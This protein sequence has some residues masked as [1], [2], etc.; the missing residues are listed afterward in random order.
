MDSKSIDFAA[1]PQTAIKF[2]TSPALFYREMPKNGGFVEPLVF[3]LVMGVVS[4]LIMAV[5][6]LLGLN[7][8]GGMAAGVTSIIFF[9]IVVVIAGF[10]GAAIYFVIWK[11]MGSQENYETAYRCGAYASAFS[12]IL[13]IV[14]LIPY[15]GIVVSMLVCLY[16]L[17]V[18]S[19]EVHKIPS[20]KAWL[21]FGIFVAILIVV[22]VS[23]QMAA[24]KF[25]GQMKETTKQ[26][27]DE[28]G[29]AAKSQQQAVPP[30]GEAVPQASQAQE[31]AYKQMDEAIRQM[32][33]QMSSLPPDQQAQ[34]RITIDQMK[35]A[36]NKTGR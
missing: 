14:G 27:Q 31:A 13:T 20:G 23:G 2:I 21:V 8:A 32:E 11:L 26:M 22:G 6:S 29:E 16:L 35:A 3:M 9:P 12:P 28:A 10:I 33:A 18:A 19:V 1:I 4:G 24:R 34:M 36:R 5:A 15:A 25:S 7:L 17:V 30:Q